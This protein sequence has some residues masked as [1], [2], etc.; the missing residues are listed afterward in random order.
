MTEIKKLLQ[1]MES[2]VNFAIAYIYLF[3]SDNF[4]IYFDYIFID[5]FYAFMNRG[6]LE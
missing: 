4:I 6:L 2:T 5:P 1:N 3:L